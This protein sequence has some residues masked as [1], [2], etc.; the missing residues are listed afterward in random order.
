MPP[1]VLRNV[2]L[3]N[4]V[5]RDFGTQQAVLL[6]ERLFLVFWLSLITALIA[7]RCCALVMIELS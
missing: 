5:L 4:V 2:P 7:F 3:P 1:D 6:H